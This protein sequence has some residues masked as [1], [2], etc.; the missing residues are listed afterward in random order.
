[1]FDL[2]RK[3]QLVCCEGEE[4]DPAP[5]GDPT[6]A[7][8]PASA[9]PE[10]K[11]TQDDMNRCLAE[12][13]RKHKEKYERLEGSY[14]TLLRDKTMETSTRATMES[15]LEDLR[16]GFRTKEQ[17]AEVDKKRQKEEYEVALGNA[18]KDVV[19]YEQLYTDT[20]ITQSLQD[21]AV[22]GEAFNN[23]Q[24]IGLLKPITELRELKD[25]TGKTIGNGPMVDFP[26][27]DEKTGKPIKTLRTPAE[28]V[29]RMKE[30]TETY[31][32]LF[33][34]NVVSGVGQGAATGSGISGK[35]GQID[36][37]SLTT[38]QYLKIRKEQPEL[39]N[40]RPKQ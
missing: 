39:L 11:F 20:V 17:Q 9:T 31:G 26:D 29:K 40:L 3:P 21:A 15:E 22:N 18:K 14:E 6:P 34:A 33:R 7:G 12:D 4:G 2:Y 10:G 23:Q 16:A 25:D 35:T 24:I 27:V 1:M 36:V 19:K 13:R 28:A 37:A 5:V 38:E 30:L 32:N 8:D